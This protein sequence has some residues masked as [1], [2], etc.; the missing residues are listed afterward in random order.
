MNIVFYKE[1]SHNRHLMLEL[2][3][4]NIIQMKRLCIDSSI[5]L[6]LK[7]RINASFAFIYKTYK[8]RL[9]TKSSPKCLKDHLCNEK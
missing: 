2:V 4:K 5:L 6:A 7:L 8:N 1:N 9:K 3:R